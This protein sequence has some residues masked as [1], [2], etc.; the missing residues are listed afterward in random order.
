V[1][2]EQRDA[3]ALAAFTA[4]LL[5][6]GPRLDL[7][8]LALLVLGLA[9]LLL[10][11]VDPGTQALL[12]ISIATALVQHYHA[13]RCALDQAVFSHWAT[14]WSGQ[15]VADP[16]ADLDAF[17]Q[18]LSA[19]GQGTTDEPPRPLPERVRGALRLLRRQMLA[20]GVQFAAIVAAILW[21]LIGAA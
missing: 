4:A 9:T 15:P 12:A 19:V 14:G 13:F 7:V 8:S 3:A 21:R 18:A 1:A 11:V 2:P 5:A 20:L 17:D 6:Q 16:Q 10:A